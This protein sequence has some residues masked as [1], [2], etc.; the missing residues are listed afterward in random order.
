VDMIY[1]YFSP[2]GEFMVFSSSDCVQ[3]FWFQSK[4]ALVI[5]RFALSSKS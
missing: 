3:R 1:I 2:S 5:F 4:Q